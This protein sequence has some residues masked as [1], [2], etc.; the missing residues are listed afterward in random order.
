MFNQ[1]V[2]DH[3]LMKTLQSV[4]KHFF[5]AYKDSVLKFLKGH[6]TKV[7]NPIIYTLSNITADNSGGYVVTINCETSSYYCSSKQ[8]ITM[9]PA[10]YDVTITRSMI[11]AYTSIML[12][13]IENGPF[14]EFQ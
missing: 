8:R 13:Q 2:I 10:T 6:K 5:T 4:V 7:F 11:D 9:P 14:S 12:D 3:Y 1:N